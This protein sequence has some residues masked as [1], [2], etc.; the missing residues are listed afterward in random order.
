M[1]NKHQPALASISSRDEVNVNGDRQ[2]KPRRWLWHWLVAV[3]VILAFLVV[4][5]AILL[6]MR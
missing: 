2:R 5:C 1:E 6:P 3:L 4:E